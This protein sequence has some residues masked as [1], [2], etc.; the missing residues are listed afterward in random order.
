MTILLFPPFLKMPLYQLLFQ[1]I[2]PK[3]Q[4]KQ[5]TKKRTAR[6]NYL[7][8]KLVYLEEDEYSRTASETE[9]Q[10]GLWRTLLLDAQIYLWP[11]KLIN[12]ST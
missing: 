2:I 6:S 8:Q 9:V 3:K 10:S 11:D 1:Y 7:H 4:Q 12:N 5:I